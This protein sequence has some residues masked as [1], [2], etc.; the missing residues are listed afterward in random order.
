VF[1]IFVNYRTTDTRFGAAA[2]YELL[3]SRFGKERIFLDNQSMDPGSIYPQRIDD[4]LETV[5]VLLVLVGPQWLA[6]EPRSPGRLLIHRENDWVRREIRTAFARGIPVI[7]V[8][9]DGAELP[10]AAAL[11]DDIA[12]LVYRQTMVVRHQHLGADVGELAG[13]IDNLLAASSGTFGKWRRVREVDDPVLLGVHPSPVRAVPTTGT[14][15]DPVLRVPAYVSREVA[16]RLTWALASTSFVLIVGDATAGK[17]RLA[18][19]VVREQLPDHWLVVPERVTE[20]AEALAWARQA[21]DCVVWLDDLERYLGP[22][23]LT[24]QTIS[25]LSRHV[26]LLGTIRSQEHAQL[27]PRWERIADEPGRLRSRLGRDVVRLAHEIRL[28][29]RWSEAETQRASMSA[30]PRVAE[31]ARYADEFGIAEYLGAGPQ[32]LTEWRDAWSPGHH[33]RAAALV[34]AAVD[35]YRAGVR[36]GIGVGLLRQLHSHY[37]ASRGGEALRPEPF[38]EALGWVTETLHATSSLLV[39][40]GRG[41]YRPFGYLIDAV[42]ADP[43]QLE[44]LAATWRVV[45]NRMPAAECWHIGEAAYARRL[46]DV[47][48]SAYQRAASVGNWSAELKIADCIGESGRRAEAVAVLR[49]IVDARTSAVGPRHSD[50]VEARQALAGWTGRAGDPRAAVRLLDELVQELATTAG[51]THPDTLTARHALANWLGRA[52]RLPDAVAEFQRL[53]EDR[54]RHD[55]LDHPH[56]LTARH[57]LANWLGRSGRLEKALHEHERVA[58]ARTRVLGADHPDTLRSRHRLSRLVCE[59][60]GTDAGLPL[61]AQVIAD[62]TRVLGPDHPETLRT[63][64]QHVRWTGKAGSSVDALGLAEL[65]VVDSSRVLGAEHPDTLRARHQHARWTSEAGDHT[66]AATLFRELI[67]DWI[68]LFGPNHPYTLISRYRLVLAVDGTG[69]RTEARLLLANQL[70]DDVTALG[71]HHP[72]TNHAREMLADWDDGRRGAVARDAIG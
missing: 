42:E 29:R 72:Y 26:V 64:S 45:I 46:L 35:V 6:E 68:R 52:G 58:A 32:L 34:A 16:G 38:D 15:G 48:R 51:R 67:A 57:E 28:S 7:P 61:L 5:R 63:R 23:G 17:T 65:L 24:V 37:L 59:V 2:T 19:E 3:A 8:L 36:R 44:I 69:A 30:D 71:E 9:L 11:P 39:P 25:D 43:E 49:R 41:R 53:V 47:A 1:E 31:A 70:A 60:R 4:A 18:Y 40:T 66:G 12:P 54:T 27:S 13:V 62:R 14:A 33:P 21:G 50:V 22:D 20:L 55:G 56:T 10:D